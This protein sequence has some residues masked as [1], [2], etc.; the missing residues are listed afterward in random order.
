MLT[1]HVKIARKKSF[2]S[3][4]VRPKEMGICLF[5]LTP[6]LMF[7]TENGVSHCVFIGL[8]SCFSRVE[9]Q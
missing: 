6:E 9:V 8:H 1:K 5:N 3:R 4:T 2:P 7:Y